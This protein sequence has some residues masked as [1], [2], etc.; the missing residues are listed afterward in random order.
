[1]VAL[2]CLWDLRDEIDDILLRFRAVC[3]TITLFL[4]SDGNNCLIHSLN[5]IR[6]I[7]FLNQR[8]RFLCFFPKSDDAL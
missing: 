5:L 7:Y 8:I 2:I 6:P 4:V 1:L 3:N